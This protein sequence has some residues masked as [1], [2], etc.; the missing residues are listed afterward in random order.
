MELR[1]SR[2]L[3]F[4]NFRI[5][6]YAVPEKVLKHHTVARVKSEGKKKK[7]KKKGKDHYRLFVEE[8]SKRMSN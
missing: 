6:R 2:S 8:V 4:Q 1:N 3:G 7:K 5:S